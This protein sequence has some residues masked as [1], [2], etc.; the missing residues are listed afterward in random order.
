MDEI[1]VRPVHD[2]EWRDIRDLRLRALHDEAADIAFIDTVAGATARSDEFWQRRA[3]GASVEAG[4]H[5]SA[6]QFVAVAPDG[7]W[8]GTVT[9]LIERAGDNDFESLPIRRSGGA[10]VGVYLDPEYRGRG[11]IQNLFDIAVDWVR[12]RG[13]D[14]ARLYVHADN[15]RAQKAYEKAGFHFTGTTLVGS[16]GP[17]VEMAREV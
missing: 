8:V 16:V 2:Y 12:E 15:L 11:V 13:L 17:E 3:I 10:A 14:Y 6:R 7:T 1:T 5:A 9:I 4:E